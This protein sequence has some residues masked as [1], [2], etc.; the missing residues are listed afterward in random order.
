M[1]N[2]IRRIQAVANVVVE[3]LDALDM[4]TDISARVLTKVTLNDMDDE[5]GDEDLH[6]GIVK[7]GLCV[8]CVPMLYTLV[9]SIIVI[10]G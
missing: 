10:L 5:P 3:E 2:F 1:S 7:L 9:S 8:A 4:R 6:F